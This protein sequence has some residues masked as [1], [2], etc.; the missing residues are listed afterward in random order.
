MIVTLKRACLTCLFE[1]LC[2]MWYVAA[3]EIVASVW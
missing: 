1:C 3:V 2:C